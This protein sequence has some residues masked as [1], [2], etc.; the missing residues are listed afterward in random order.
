V[1][2]SRC[3]VVDKPLKD[4]SAIP[5]YWLPNP[6]GEGRCPV[7]TFRIY[8]SFFRVAMENLMRLSEALRPHVQPA[9]SGIYLRTHD[10]Q[11]ALLE[12]SDFCRSHSCPL[13]HWDVN[14]GFGGAAVGSPLEAIR[15]LW[16]IQGPAIVIL[17]AFHR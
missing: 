8:M 13:Y 4:D 14:N 7:W 15:S 9:I 11:E 3:I 6:V 5:G 12:V 17:R 1:T 16:Q 10:V 2:P